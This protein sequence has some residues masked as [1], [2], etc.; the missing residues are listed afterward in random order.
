M[1]ALAFES[2]TCEEAIPV[3]FANAP[4]KFVRNGKPWAP[5]DTLRHAPAI[6]RDR[7]EMIPRQAPTQKREVENERK[8]N[9]RLRLAD[10]GVPDPGR[11][12]GSELRPMSRPL[13]AVSVRIGVTIQQLRLCRKESEEL[14][15]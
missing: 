9:H 1:V 3:V 4:I 11:R 15:W 10:R 8:G 14:Q 5:P 7:P 12:D 2:D 6:F 13:W